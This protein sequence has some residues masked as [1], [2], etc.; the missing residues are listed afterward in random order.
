[1]P[2]RTECG[3]EKLIQMPRQPQQIKFKKQM[4]MNKTHIQKINE[5]YFFLLITTLAHFF[6]GRD[7]TSICT[8]FCKV[9]ESDLEP[10]SRQMLITNYKQ[11]CV[12]W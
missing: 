7:S 8:K 6:S 2:L 5:P 10:T 11:I 4:L 9:K 3:I 12:Q 1:M